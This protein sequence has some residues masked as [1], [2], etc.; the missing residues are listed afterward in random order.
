MT[1]A[2]VDSHIHLIDRK[3]LKYSWLD[4]VSDE[5]S[6][7]LGDYSPL[8]RDFAAGDFLAAALPEGLAKIV[9]VEA[10]FGSE[11]VAET[12]WLQTEADSIGIPMAIIGRADLASEG[13][14]ALLDRHMAFPAFRGVRMLWGLGTAPAD[15]FRRG[16][17]ELVDRDLI[18]EEPATFDQFS[19]LAR[20]AGDFPSARIILGHC[21]MPLARDAAYLDDWRRALGDLARQPN[22]ACKISG[23]AM[24]DHSWTFDRMKVVTDAVIDAFGAERTFMGSN[25]PVESLYFNSYGELVSTFRD[26]IAD[27]DAG[28]RAALMSGTASRIF[29]I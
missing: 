12:E 26:L 16:F 10:A 28:E 19:A 1:E 3:R 13:V 9:H 11:P 17:A 24:T 23:L 8:M 22:V 29:R 14:G 6:G 5:W 2:W 7:I 18:F 20:L 21:G 4:R 15:E 27:R 25:W